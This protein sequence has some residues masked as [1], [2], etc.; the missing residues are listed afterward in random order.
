MKL[1][2][3]DV[4]TYA[5]TTNLPL[6]EIADLSKIPNITKPDFLVVAG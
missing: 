3:T 2:P 5:Q 6:Y 4:A 1:T